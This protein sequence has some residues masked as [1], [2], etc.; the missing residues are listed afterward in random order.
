MLKALGVLAVVAALAVTLAGCGGSAA[1]VR[2]VTTAATISRLSRRYRVQRPA[3]KRGPEARNATPQP[4][5]VRHTGPVPILVYHGLGRAPAGAAFPR[6]Y[7]SKADFKAEMAWLH[8]HRYQAVTL[9]RVMI[10]WFHGGTL[11][12]KPVVITFDNGYPPQV[13]FAP[14]VMARYGWPGVLY[15]ITAHHLSKAQIRH[16]LALG[17]E[18]GS[19]SVSHPNLTALPAVELHYQVFT[20]R[21]FLRRA[22]KA[23]V[24]SFS[25]PSSKYDAAVVGAVKAAGYKDAVTEGHAYA[26]RVDPYLLPRFEIEGGVAELAADLATSH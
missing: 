4:G 20:S 2:P 21:A 25:Y 5:W 11:P 12:E 23:P 24:D 14:E 1:R 16:V 26:T 6:L 9:A 18:I 13:T 19:H 3:P 17:W 8:A 7:V 22:L 15:E 10:A